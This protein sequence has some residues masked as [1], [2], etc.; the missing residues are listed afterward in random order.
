[1]KP[2]N[3]F[4]KP[5]Q[6]SAVTLKNSRNFTFKNIEI[7]HS[8]K[9]LTLENCHNCRVD[10]YNIEIDANNIIKRYIIPSKDPTRYSTI[11]TLLAYFIRVAFKTKNNFI[12]IK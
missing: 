3:S 2:Y 12:T 8:P 5:P 9:S 7:L 11:E 6:P 1:M 10:G 4:S